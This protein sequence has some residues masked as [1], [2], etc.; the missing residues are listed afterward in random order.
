MASPGK[1]SQHNAGVTVVQTKKQRSRADAG[2]AGPNVIQSDAS[3]TQT[4]QEGPEAKKRKIN[5]K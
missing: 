1:E 3:S 2:L 4:K 5:P